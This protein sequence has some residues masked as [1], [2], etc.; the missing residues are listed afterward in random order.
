MPMAWPVTSAEASEARKVT[1]G[2]TS[3]T[4][5]R[6]SSLRSHCGTGCPVR[7]DSSRSGAKTGIVLVI[8][9]AA[10]GTIA[11]TVMFAL[12]SS[13]AQVRAMATMPALA[14]A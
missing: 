8:S 11:F 4:V 7:S 10:T 2:A 6:P 5:P 12:A 1:S 9:V 14:A 13:I 3:S